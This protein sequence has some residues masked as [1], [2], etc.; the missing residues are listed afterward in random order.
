MM[1]FMCSHPFALINAHKENE[2]VCGVLSRQAKS[3]SEPGWKDD[4]WKC[5]PNELRESLKCLGCLLHETYEMNMMF[6]ILG[7]N[8][9]HTLFGSRRIM[10]R[11]PKMPL[12]MTCQHTLI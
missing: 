7:N 3:S 1:M 8:R 11:K 4:P 9:E 10:W 5:F 12:L 2:L 6:E